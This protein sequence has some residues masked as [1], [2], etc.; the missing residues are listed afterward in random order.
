MG[1]KCSRQEKGQ[2]E[3]QPPQA[4]DGHLEEVRDVEAGVPYGFMQ[5]GNHGSSTQ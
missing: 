5:E 3:I 4:E 1:G 2:G